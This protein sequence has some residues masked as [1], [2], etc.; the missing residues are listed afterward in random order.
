MFNVVSLNK[1]TVGRELD[2]I[3]MGSYRLTISDSV[4]C[5]PGFAIMQY[6]FAS[7]VHH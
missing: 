7:V 2:K 4:L 6:A 3:R 1:A 5:K